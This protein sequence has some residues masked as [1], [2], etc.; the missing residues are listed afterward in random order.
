M[1]AGASGTG[2]FFFFIASGAFGSK[3]A[4]DTVFGTDLGGGFGFDRILAVAAF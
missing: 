2:S 1:G 3:F 4:D